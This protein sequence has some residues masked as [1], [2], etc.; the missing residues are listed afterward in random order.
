MA[1][2]GLGGVSIHTALSFLGAKSRGPPESCIEVGPA[3]CR[4]QG[5]PGGSADLLWESFLPPASKREFC[6]RA[7]ALPCSPSAETSGLGRQPKGL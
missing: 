3:L 4:S 1:E 2:A 7:R 5:V 6:V